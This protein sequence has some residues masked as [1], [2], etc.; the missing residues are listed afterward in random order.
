MSDATE[1]TKEYALARI[2]ELNDF[3]RMIGLS[4]HPAQGQFVV[5]GPNFQ[6]DDTRVGYCVQVRKKVGQFGSDMVFLRH[7]NGSLTVHENQCY[8]A[9][10]AEQEALARSVFE[11]LPED[12]E[13]E[14][15]YSDCE[16]VHEIGFVIEHS[17]SCGTPDVPFAITIGMNVRTE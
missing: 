9:M 4:C 3:Q 16:K 1:M 15:G 2:I 14:Q 7:V 12:E 11:V 17:K 8:C 6:G 13:H 10:N 5:T